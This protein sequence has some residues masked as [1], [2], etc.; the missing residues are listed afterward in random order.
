MALVTAIS[1]MTGRVIRRATASPV[2]RASS[3]ASPAAP[4][5]ARSSAVF[6][7]RSAGLRPG[8]GGEAV[9]LP[10]DP[11]GLVADLD[12]G[13]GLRGLVQDQLEAGRGPGVVGV[14]G[15]PGRERDRAGQVGPL[16]GGQ[17]GDV[18]GGED[19]GE[20]G[21][22]RDRGQRD[23]EERQRQPQAQ[24]PAAARG[25]VSGDRGFSHRG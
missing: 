1:R 3:A 9:R 18:G 23:A 7:P 16:L 10:D 12:G 20:P 2:S 11:P 4:A 19:R 22:Q 21:Q 14:V 15:H 17:V 6:R 8:R 5:M 13:P 25:F 24:G